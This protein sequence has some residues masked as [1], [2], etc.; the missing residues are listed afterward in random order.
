MHIGIVGSGSFAE[1]LI[2]IWRKTHLLTV[3]VYDTTVSSSLQKKYP[4]VTFTTDMTDMIQDVIVL[5]IPASVLHLYKNSFNEQHVIIVSKGVTQNGKL[6]CDIFPKSLYLSGP[7]LAK[8]K[9]SSYFATLSGPSADRIKRRIQTPHFFIQTHKASQRE[10]QLLSICKN[11]CSFIIGRAEYAGISENIQAVICTKIL[12]N[13][14][15][16][17]S[18]SQ[19]HFFMYGGFADFLATTLSQTSRNKQ[20]GLVKKPKETVESLQSIPYVQYFFTKKTADF[21]KQIQ[22]ETRK[23]YITKLCAEYTKK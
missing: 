21:I 19:T 18:I 8:S 16:K 23:T 12:D 1:L 11:I 10:M 14:L 2:Q 4:R 6:P 3:Y 15:S 7:M 20:A 17:N 22:K 13:L 9:D 5:A